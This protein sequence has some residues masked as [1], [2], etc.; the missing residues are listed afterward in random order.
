VGIR[1]NRL[2]SAGLSA[3]IVVLAMSG[4]GIAA[5]ASPVQGPDFS[6]T[7]GIDTY[8]QSRGIDPSAAIWQTG[9]KNYV[10]DSCPGAG[11]HCIAPTDTPVVQ[12]APAGGTNVFTCSPGTRDG[13]GSCNVLQISAG[14]AGD[15]SGGT[16]NFNC[17]EGSL[18]NP[19]TLDASACGSLTQVNTTGDNRATIVQ[20]IAQRSAGATSQSAT[21]TAG[22]PNTPFTQTN[23]SGTNEITIGQASLQYSS[24]TP[25]A[26]ETA[27]ATQVN[28]TGKN[29]ATVGQ[30]EQ[31]QVS[32]AASAQDQEGTQIAC[33]A[34]DSQSGPNM[35]TVGQL[36]SQQEKDSGGQGISQFQN[37]QPGE[38]NV[39]SCGSGSGES[40]TTIDP[41]LA[42]FVLQN[43]STPT[44]TG[45]NQLTDKQSL[46]QDQQSTTSSGA[47]TQQQ[48]PF[49]DTGGLEAVPAQTSTGLS[50]ADTSQ[51]E[52]QNMQASTTGAL[53][54]TQNDPLRQPTGEGFQTSN[55]G[56]TFT[57]TQTGDQEAGAGAQQ[58]YDIQGDCVSSGT[59]N[60]QST[61]TTNGTPH[62]SSCTST[63]TGCTAGVNNEEEC[64]A[65]S[66]AAPSGS[67]QSDIV[68][69][70][71]RAS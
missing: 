32:D 30:L 29:Q 10:G 15:P 60:V 62:P 52:K 49:G 42:S 6:T 54:Q 36:M 61:A 40:F 53:S 5:S 57:L 33:V 50:T 13:S 59:C 71:S 16:N 64:D 68:C 26:A 22:T 3:V 7:Q 45:Q 41:N 51:N 67:A 19:A 66:D 21:E 43:Q 25:T 8:L 69:D 63:G 1:H 17:D 20:A 37:R 38:G 58:N 24:D 46:Q 4:T 70:A 44:A 14:T 39:S 9:L 31:Q 34:Q 56:D 18:A 47:V 27:Y 65:A 2:L 12:I 48:G 55:S 11:W 23:V 28:G 35:A